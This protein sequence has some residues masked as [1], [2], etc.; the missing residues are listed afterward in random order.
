MKKIIAIVIALVLSVGVGIAAGIAWKQGKYLDAIKAEEAARSE[1]AGLSVAIEV[2]QREIERRVTEIVTL[3]EQIEAV[4]EV[5]GDARTVEVIKWRSKEI[6][7][8]GEK[9]YVPGETV[10]LPGDTEY[11]VGDCPV[12]PLPPVAFDV[13]GGEARLESEAGNYWAVGSVELW[14]LSPPPEEMLGTAG[15]RSDLTELT[16]PEQTK[17]PWRLSLAAFGSTDASV[18][19]GLQM[20]SRTRW[21]A[22]AGWLSVD[23]GYGRSGSVYVGATYQIWP[24]KR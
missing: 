12:R 19:L 10:Y 1:V 23:G 6:V 21:G 4:R 24:W 7:V 15:W 14:R 8:P 17:P 2:K 9:V 11:V 18:G 3:T 5:A 13:R 20:Q 16:R 22:Q